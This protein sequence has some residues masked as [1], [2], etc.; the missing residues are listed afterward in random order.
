[1]RGHVFASLALTTIVL[2]AAA[3]SAEPTFQWD[4]QHDGGGNY[5]DDGNVALVDPQG[6]LI[7]GGES[8]DT[9]AGS[10]AVTG[11]RSGACAGPPT[12]ATTWP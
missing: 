3:A 1:M 4:D 8:T 7:V 5:T 9:I 12:T 6:N 11:P 10:A 2:M